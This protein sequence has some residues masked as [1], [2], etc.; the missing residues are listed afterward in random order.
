MKKNE[1]MFDRFIKI[2]I[3]I[4]VLY[5]AIYYKVNIWL[6]LVVLFGSLWFIIT[7]LIG[8]CPLYNLLG[9]NTAKK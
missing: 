5:F 3:G 9:I 4:I 8:Y 7:G 6:M 1:N 2:L